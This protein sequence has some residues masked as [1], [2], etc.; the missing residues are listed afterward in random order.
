MVESGSIDFVFSFDS[1]VHAEADVMASYSRE[2]ARVLKR[3]GSA[4]I[5]YSNFES[6]VRHSLLY[7]V[8]KRVRKVLTRIGGRVSKAVA[9][10]HYAPIWRA[11]TMSADKMRAF[12][13]DAGM[14]CMKQEIIPWGNVR[15]LTD[16]MSTIVNTP[17][18]SCEV[19]KNPRFMVEAAA[20]K[21]LSSIGLRRDEK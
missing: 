9:N 20:I 11:S 12:A 17:G 10:I 2:I 15:R 4:F 13:A 1:L 8:G 3:D 19:I 18:G 16:C 21:R 5:H 6:V 7:P 14:S